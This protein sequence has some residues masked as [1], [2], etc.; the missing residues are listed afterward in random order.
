MTQEKEWPKWT[1]EDPVSDELITTHWARY[2]KMLAITARRT[3]RLADDEIDDLRGD[4]VIK[5]LRVPQERRP[6]IGYIKT[7]LTNTLRTALHDYVSRGATPGVSWREHKTFDYVQAAPETPKG[8]EASGYDAL[9]YISPLDLPE[10]TMNARIDIARA[11]A[12]LP[13]HEQ[14]IVELYLQ[15]YSGR[16]IAEELSTSVSV[17][18][19]VVFKLKNLLRD[20]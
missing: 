13:A 4:L 6:Y 15:G 2:I 14:Q 19:L 10:D 3:Y 12:T 5:L 11:V 18:W 7:T 9:D 16:E 17:A 1:D 20:N 8:D